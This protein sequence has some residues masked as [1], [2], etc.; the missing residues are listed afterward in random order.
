MA[1][2]FLFGLIAHVAQCESSQNEWR[3]MS[4]GDIPSRIYGH[5]IG[6]YN[7]SL[8]IIGGAYN[9]SSFSATTYHTTL[10]NL[11]IANSSWRTISN[12]LDY[13]YPFGFRCK[14]QCYTSFNEFIFI[15]NPESMFYD[16][17]GYLVIYNMQKQSFVS[18]STFNNTLVYVESGQC[19]TNNGSHIF[20]IGRYCTLRIGFK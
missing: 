6:I 5:S 9:D 4:N 11:N 18:P 8:H 14:G 20:A 17:T 3:T 7:H 12:Q 2:S 10:N 19:A 16:E 13:R 1:A 15:I